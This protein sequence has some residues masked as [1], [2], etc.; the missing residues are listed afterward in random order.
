MDNSEYMS[1]IHNVKAEDISDK[2]KGNTFTKGIALLQGVWF[3]TQCL[4]RMH[5]HLPVTQLEVATLAFAII[6]VLIWV[7]WWAKPLDVHHPILVGSDVYLKEVESAI[8][9]I[10]IGT[11]FGAI[12]CAAWNTDFPSTIE[13]WMWRAC[14][15]MVTTIPAAL[16]LVIALGTSIGGTVL[17]DTLDLICIII[18]FILIPLYP[19][20]RLFLITM[21]FTSLRALPPGTFIDVD[22]S[23]YIPHL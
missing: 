7:L 6:N 4:A 2:S 21:T 9:V 1:A 20:A 12:H 3:V 15:L 5:Q 23:V 18:V 14:S 17:K 16:G 13:M 10:L 11:I 8:I 22:W 19:I